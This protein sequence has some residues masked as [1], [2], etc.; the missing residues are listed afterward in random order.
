M[1]FFRL[2]VAALLLTLTGCECGPQTRK[3]FPKIEVLD[4]V[5]NSRTA[6]DFGTVQLNFT[7]PRRC[8]FATQARPR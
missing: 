3:L 4:D 2:T 7:P 1:T 5:G 8:A 6:V